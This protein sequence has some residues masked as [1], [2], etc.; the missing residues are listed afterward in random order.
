MNTTRITLLVGLALA[1][2]SATAHAQADPDAAYLVTGNVA[3]VSDYLY[4][5]LTNSWGGPAVQGGADFTMKNGLAAGIWASS[6]SDKSYAGASVEIDVYASYGTQFNPDWSWRV[7]LCSYLYPNGNLDA[8]GLPSQS[9]NT[10]EANAALT[11]KWLTL[12]YS[13]ALTDYFAIDTEQG[14]RSDSKGTGYV[15][16]DAALPLNAQWSL[17]LHVGHLDVTTELATPL[18]NGAD[19]PDYT[20]F[21]A[22]L[23]YQFAAHWSASLGITYA[24]NES[25]YGDTVSF[26][27]PNDTR[28]IG[29][30]R[31]FLM[32]QGTF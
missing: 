31:G 30:T 6:T 13:S 27:N 11:W 7:G 20:D 9:F 25:F 14:Y 26:T 22:T 5:G 17:A 32:L 12:K 29:G 18:A 16:L 24:D 23:K 8:A 19:D 3:L 1:V 4:R 15:Q 21:G 10:T 2:G 28:N